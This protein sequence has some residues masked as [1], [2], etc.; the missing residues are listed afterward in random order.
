MIPTAGCC[1]FVSSIP[2]EERYK[3]RLGRGDS[4]A[5]SLLHRIALFCLDELAVPALCSHHLGDLIDQPLG[6]FPA[7]AR[8]GDRVQKVSIEQLKE[9]GLFQKRVFLLLIC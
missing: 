7:Q 1:T 8:V 9:K 3:K 6:V 4:Q 5:E 2:D